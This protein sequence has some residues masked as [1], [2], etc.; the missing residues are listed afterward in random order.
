MTG[1][2]PDT[3][4]P[5]LDRLRARVRA[6]QRVTSAP[7]V[8]FGA[9]ILGYAVLGGLYAGQLPAGGRHLTLLVYWPL[10][11]VIGF[12][13]LWRSERRRAEKEGVGAGRRTYGS[14]TRR[15]LIAL[16]LIV[17]LFIPVLFVGVFAPMIW[18]AGVL[19][20][21]ASWR[22]DRPLGIWA[23]V[24]GVTGGAESV[25]VIA[26]GGLSAGWWW[27]QPA[28]YTALGLALVIGGLVINRREQ[29]TT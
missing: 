29:R 18:P 9:L 16:V 10:A 19:A 14:A 15:Y 1:T 20:A 6:D 5:D 13:V 12:V 28:V 24:I 8:A 11:T 7:M 2:D 27:L 23:A 21:I 26:N 17:V 4:L 25:Y 3:L 22:H